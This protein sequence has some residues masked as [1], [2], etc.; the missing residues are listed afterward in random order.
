[1]QSLLPYVIDPLLN[2]VTSGSTPVSSTYLLLFAP[3]HAAIPHLHLHQL[4]LY[5]AV[6]YPSSTPAQ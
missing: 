3:P 1:M 4:H 6:L 2:L 5:Y